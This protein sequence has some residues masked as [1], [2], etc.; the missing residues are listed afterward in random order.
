MQ[1]KLI[2]EGIC[3]LDFFYK[4][5]TDIRSVS[6]IEQEKIRRNWFIPCKGARLHCFAL[7]NQ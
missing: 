4:K 2:I 5:E 6:L 3:S 1:H 7:F